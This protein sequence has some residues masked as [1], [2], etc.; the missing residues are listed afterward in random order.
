MTAGVHFWGLEVMQ[1]GTRNGWWFFGVCRP[2]IDL[3]EDKHFFDRDGTWVIMMGQSNAPVWHLHCS[4]CEGAGMIMTLLDPARKMPAGSR[5]GLVLDLDNGGTLTMY[6][7]SK[8]CGTIA[9]GLVGPLLPCIA[10]YYEGKV[11][12]I[13]GG[14]A[15]T[16]TT[17]IKIRLVLASFSLYLRG[18]CSRAPF[19]TLIINGFKVFNS[20][21]NASNCVQ[22][23]D[24]PPPSAKK[25]KAFWLSNTDTIASYQVDKPACSNV[26]VYIL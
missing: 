11:V 24:L 21:H 10:S 22:S 17:T 19:V 16:T 26:R 1:V 9:T 7:D 3:N 23:C 20:V 14:L 8:P 5:I 6:L 2:G 4:T 13:H 15:C 25:E 18:Y 12:K